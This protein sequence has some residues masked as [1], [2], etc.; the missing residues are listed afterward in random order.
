MLDGD[1]QWD[2]VVRVDAQ[3]I[4]FKENNVGPDRSHDAFRKT[5][6]YNIRREHLPRVSSSTVLERPSPKYL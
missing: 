6:G 4:L 5:G 3:S 2:I 1:D